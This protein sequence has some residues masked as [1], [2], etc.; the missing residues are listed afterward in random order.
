MPK[1]NKKLRLVAPNA[2]E[3][4]SGRTYPVARPF[5]TTEADLKKIFSV[6]IS[7]NYLSSY[8]IHDSDA[9]IAI[10]TD[11]L[12]SGDIVVTDD[13]CIRRYYPAPGGRTRLESLVDDEWA[14]VYRPGEVKII[15]RVLEIQRYTKKIDTALLLRPFKGGAI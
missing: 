10:L 8:G 4:Q 15:A 9:L 6:S 12:Q 11:D 5:G 7:D 2:A 13:K 14:D 1:P 3:I